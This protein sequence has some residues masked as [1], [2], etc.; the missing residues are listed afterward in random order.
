MSELRKNPFTGEWT[1][2]AENR[3]NRPYEFVH[4]TEMKADSSRTCPFCGGHEQ[5]TTEAVYQD[6]DDDRWQIRV[7]PNM[8]PAV[9]NEATPVAEETFYEQTAG[10]GRHEVLVDTPKHETTIDQFSA[11]RIHRVLL[12]LQERYTKILE[13]EATVYVQIFKNCGASAG[14]S[15]H[16][17]HWQMMGLPI[18]PKRVGEMA[19]HIKKDDC[20]FC[21][22]LT[23]EKQNERRVVFENKD[24][25]AI[26]PYASRFPY[27]VW[28]CP[29]EHTR[30]YGALMAD[31]M[32]TL[33]QMLQ[34][35]LPK[36]VSLRPEIGY[37]IC[38][39]DAPKGEDF[40]WHLEI[41]PRIGGMA[42]F[43]FATNSYINPV[44]PESA[45][46]YYKQ[47]DENIKETL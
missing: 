31:K 28:I 42:G 16:H 27:E 23:Y 1:L 45:A 44:L 15:M 24:F 7:F 9:S 20:L 8:F 41:L 26:A 5:W 3:Q 33:S 18:V 21:K 29:K 14:M 43:E 37:N 30:N 12:V 25:L 10:V 40:H 22:M 19:K 34:K 47:Q 39:V 17:S 35:I 38:L 36:V 32:T 2:C 6:G 4:K 13:M 11:E 46:G